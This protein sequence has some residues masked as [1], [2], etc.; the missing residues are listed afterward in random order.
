MTTFTWDCK[1]VDAYPSYD[2]LTDVVYNVH[3][4]VNGEREHEGESYSGS[5]IGTIQISLEDISPS[6]FIP[7]DELT[8]EVVV[9]WTKTAM[10][11]EEVASIEANVD[12]QID[13]K[14]TPQSITITL[15]S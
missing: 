2:S 4:I 14:I 6:T 7:I 15:A 9:E 12:A 10:G 5:C 8:N 11:P 13:N 3:W 1:T